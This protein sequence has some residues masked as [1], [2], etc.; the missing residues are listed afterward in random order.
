MLKFSDE[1]AAIEA[2]SQLG[3]Q[4]LFR[5]FNKCFFICKQSGVLAQNLLFLSAG[6]QLS[7]PADGGKGQGTFLTS[8][9]MGGRCVSLQKT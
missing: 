7:C 4:K 9:K 8:K 3:S 6:I 1:C 2:Q 5:S